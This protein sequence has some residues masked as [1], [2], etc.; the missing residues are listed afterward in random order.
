M[1]DLNE[2]VIFTKVV[3]A[4][5]FSGAARAL[6]LPKSTVSRKITQLET[7][8]GSR[9]L[10]RT[11]RSVK[12]TEVGAAHYERC[13]R[14]VAEA[15]EAERE[16]SRMQERPRGVLRVSAPVDY[17]ATLGPLVAA[18]LAEHAEVSVALDLSNRFVDLVE[19]GYDLA[20]RAGRLDDSSLVARQLGTGLLVA[21]A[22]P[23]YLARHGTPNRPE[24]LEAHACILYGSHTHR[25]TLRF[26][27]P[28]RSVSI[29]LVPRLAVNNMTAVRDAAMAGLGVAIAPWAACRE[30]LQ[31]G[32][33]VR[34]LEDWPLD[35]GGIYAVY[36]SPR[37]LT[38]KV[39]SFIDF[40]VAQ[41]PFTIC[42]PD[43]EC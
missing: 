12:L 24:Q 17:G 8:L 7:R 32:A 18:Y 9:L 33:L 26:G 13:A 19:E 16:L 28:A 1:I 27:T 31:G 43:E 37:H 22:S 10:N 5:T 40:L 25:Q 29:S 3:E 38:P 36:P 6:G 2:L 34:L 42:Q 4:G 15:E 11:T 23:A 20:I 35:S 14:I 21:C 41:Q 39:R 30:A